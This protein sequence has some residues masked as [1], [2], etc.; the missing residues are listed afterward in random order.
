M[1][2]PR[3][4]PPRPRGFTPVHLAK[5]LKDG[6]SHRRRNA[7]PVVLDDHAR[8]AA[9]GLQGA[10]DGA[11][12]RD[13]LEGVADQVE[14]DA[15]DL[16]RVGRG[17]QVFRRLDFKQNFAVIANRSEMRSRQAHECREIDGAI[18]HPRLSR[19]KPRGF[20]EV[21]DM[22]EE[23]SAASPDRFEVLALICLKIG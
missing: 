11:A 8:A 6:V 5:A 22:A 2:S 20:E 19:L 1:E 7:G 12:A 14:E 13:E 10:T 9:G 23:E 16:F 15:L 18:V 4:G 21:V 17:P 3:P